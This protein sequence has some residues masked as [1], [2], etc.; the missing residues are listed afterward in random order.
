MILFEVRW[1]KDDLDNNLNFYSV[2]SD[3]RVVCWTLVKVSYDT[4]GDR[5]S[6]N[7]DWFSIRVIWLIRISSNWN[8]TN[9]LLSLPTEFH[10]QRSV[11]FE[12]KQ[13]FLFHDVGISSHEL[14]CGTCFDFNRQ[15]DYLFIVGTEEGK[16]YKCSKS[17]N[18][19]FLDTYDAHHMA[20]YATRWNSFHPKVFI[21][22]SADWTVKIWDVDFQ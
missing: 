2:S 22:C 21:S 17:Y 15:Q 14:G 4:K 3:G 1:Q 20:V 11:R 19:Q 10:W 16:I 8:S 9:L 18:N 6:C 12:D 5:C 7:V 13:W